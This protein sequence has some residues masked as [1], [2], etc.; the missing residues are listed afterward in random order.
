M[1]LANGDGTGGDHGKQDMDDQ[2]KEVNPRTGVGNEAAWG[3]QRGTKRVQRQEE[4]RAERRQDEGDGDDECQVDE[5]DRQHPEGRHRSDGRQAEEVIA[6][7]L[8]DKNKAK[9]EAEIDYPLA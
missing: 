6:Q 9:D 4:G 5:D 2:D 8:G 3:R 7:S 1:T